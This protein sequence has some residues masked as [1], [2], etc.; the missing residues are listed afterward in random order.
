MNALKSRRQRVR[1]PHY[2]LTIP[3][4]IVFRHTCQS[5]RYTLTLFFR[6]DFQLCAVKEA[7]MQNPSI[8]DFHAL[9]CHVHD[10]RAYGFKRRLCGEL[11]HLPRPPFL[12]NVPFFYL[13][14]PCGQEA[15]PV[16]HNP[17]PGR[18][19]CLLQILFKKVAAL[20]ASHP[21]LP[22]ALP[23]L[24][25]PDSPAPP[26]PCPPPVH[27]AAL[28]AYDLAGEGLHVRVAPH[29]LQVVLFPEKS[30]ALDFQLHCLPKFPVND[31]QV[32]VLHIDLLD[33]PHVPDRFLTEE[34]GC[35]VFLQK[36]IAFVFL[37]FKDV[38]D[39]GDRPL[40]LAHAPRHSFAVQFRRNDLRVQP[41][42]E[43]IKHPA[44]DG[45]LR[46]VDD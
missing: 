3:G 32:A 1:P 39:G 26:R 19:E 2:P 17:V 14:F 40:R 16:L 4:F 25:H 31:G 10:L 24:P 6:V 38:H 13:L 28:A 23:A 18:Q 41:V 34:I 22:V 29:V 46:L 9:Q 12:Q 43:L 30:P 8:V 35:V 42:H 27:R 21:F 15:L 36:G 37:V 33:L 20:T 7:E 45:R 5:T 11:H 44:D